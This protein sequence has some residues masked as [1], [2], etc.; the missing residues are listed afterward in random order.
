MPGPASIALIFLR[1]SWQEFELEKAIQKEIDEFEHQASLVSHQ[2]AWQEALR[3]VRR[4]ETAFSLPALTV[5]CPHPG[6]FLPVV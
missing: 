5:A 6:T 3:V 1:L 2:P 4:R